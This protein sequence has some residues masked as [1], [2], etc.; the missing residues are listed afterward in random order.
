[1]NETHTFED[2][3]ALCFDLICTGQHFFEDAIDV[4]LCHISVA[5]NLI[6]SENLA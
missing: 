6:G 3:L 4:G 1:M 5:Q 2:A